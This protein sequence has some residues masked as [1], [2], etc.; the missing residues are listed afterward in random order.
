M[1]AGV[2][3]L[4][5]GAAMIGI[6]SSA[7]VAMLLFV[8]ARGL[9]DPEARGWTVSSAPVWAGVVVVAAWRAGSS[10]LGDIGGAHTVLGAGLFRGDAWSVASLW[11]LAIAGVA[12]AGVPHGLLARATWAAQAVLVTALIVGPQI[13]SASAALP[14]LAVVVVVAAQ[15]AGELFVGS[16]ARLAIARTAVVAALIAGA[17]A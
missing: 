13:T 1:I 7:L 9:F 12:I 4:L 8:G 11:L 17:L 16:A 14:W 3:C 5:G 10:D 2:A 15:F 6:G